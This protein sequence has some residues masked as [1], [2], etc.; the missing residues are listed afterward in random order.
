MLEDFSSYSSGTTEELNKHIWKI[1]VKIHVQWSSALMPKGSP[2]KFLLIL[3][4][5][6]E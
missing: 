3:I 6:L 5:I 2:R 4:F 1:Q